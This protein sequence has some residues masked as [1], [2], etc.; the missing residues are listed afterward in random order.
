[1]V[2]SVHISSRAAGLSPTAFRPQDNRS[3]A[4][5]TNSSEPEPLTLTD[6]Q[7]E[8]PLG[9]QLEI[10]EDPSRE[11]TIEQVSSLAFDS[12]F[13]PSQ[14]EVPNYG[15]TDSAYWVRVDMDNETNQTNEWLLEV[16][17]ANT[18][19][20]DLYSP[21]LDG[22]GFM[23]KQ[24]GVLRP[25]STRDVV[26]P[27]I[28][29][30]LSLPTH[31]QQTY[32]LRFQ[33][34]AS[35]TLP[36][37]LWSKD[38]FIVKAGQ[39]LIL[40]WL[41]FGG[42]LALLVYHLFLLVTLKELT[43]FYFVTL[44]TG[45]LAV[46]LEYTGYM[47]VYIFPNLYNL[48]P[49]YFPLFVALMYS[50]III[51]SD[52]FFELKIRLPKL[53]WVN[54]IL[55]VVWGVLVLLIP[56]ISYL[57]LSRLMTPMQMVS[58]A[59]TWAIGIVVWVKGFKSVRYFMLAWLGMAAS[60]FLLLLVREGIAPSTF[61]NENIFQLGFMVMAVSWSFA[62]A[63]RI[64]L[65][66]AKTENVNRELLGSEH[67][68]SQILEAMPLGVVVYGKDQ[69]PTYLN[70]RTV[71]ILSNP[72]KSIQPDL[73]AGR[74]LAQAIEYFSFQVSG[75]GEKFPIENLPIYQALNGIPACADN[76]EANFGDRQVP[77]EIW[78]SP[79]RDEAGNVESAIAVLQDI[80]PRRQVEA[81][82]AEYRRQLESLVENRTTGLNSLNKELR[83][84][85]EWLAAINLVSQVVA[86]ST[87]FTT[88][89]E[90][91]VEIINN[92]F[93]TRDS[94]IAELDI[95]AMQLK[96]LAHSCHSDLHP[97]LTESFTTL[98]D[99]ILPGSNPEQ[100]KLFFIPKEQID[101]M[102]GPIAI[103]IRDSKVQN[104]AFVPLQLREQVLGFL[105]LELSE[106]DRTIANEEIN[107]IGIFST[108]IAQ[109]I[110]SAHLF[111]QTKLLVVQEERDR[112][113]RELHDSVAQALFSANL[114]AEVL[115]QLWRRDPNRAMKSLEKLQ[116]LMRGALAEMRT[117][118]LELRPSSVINT[119]LGE[120]LAQLTEAVTS[121]SGLP[122]QLFIENIPLL[123]E[124]VQLGFYRI[125][126]EALNNVIK[127]AQAR[128]V[129]VSLSETQL[130]PDKN[131][132]AEREVKLVIQD[133]GVG[134]YMEA[135]QSSHLGI[136]IMR[137]RAGA[138]SA[139]LTLASE[140]GHGTFV[141]LIW[142]TDSKSEKST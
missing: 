89:Y 116:H 16:G 135:V 128:L 55:L 62:L 83:L 72:D 106:A 95:E 130:P 26:Y 5:A 12:Q 79:V 43:Y 111:E 90:K 137:E 47:G 13:I 119:P 139:S 85:L 122:F 27:K 59:M 118:L 141:S 63:D 56:F 41:I 57:N 24:S 138:I 105:G 58:L 98:P 102:N 80:S 32:Y 64:N 39:E 78:A 125:A 2:L 21:S 9:L 20:V 40:H 71:E 52:T 94:F 134:F 68:L 74:D 25:V 126:Q 131:Y 36:L 60:L 54:I 124:S 132:Q 77:L 91:I 18:Q 82:L 117:V 67:R 51:F 99:G 34:G 31:N 23:V 129:T 37:T 70:Q 112:L 65:L 81:E 86:Q 30:S 142:S 101:S 66:K 48:R 75:T 42:L 46:L 50:S 115:P 7:A 44:L 110:E 93:S 8:Y 121:R 6:G 96:I 22:I 108:D 73:A 53:H 114:V 45:M 133:D 76:I 1:M 61:F 84:R 109:L 38:A 15:Y 127:H 11:L 140:P 69:K 100:G 113:A 88:I 49:Y 87:N 104:I 17:F 35:M 136:N 92:L 120:L 28:V 103:H 19:F 14:V 10:L 33:S 123:P 97:D 29:F 3:I 107:L 4:Q